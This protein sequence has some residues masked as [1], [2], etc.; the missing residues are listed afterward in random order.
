MWIQTHGYYR[1]NG[2]LHNFILTNVGGFLGWLGK[3]W[4]FFYF[5]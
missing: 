2:F 5:T 3:M 4:D 1:K